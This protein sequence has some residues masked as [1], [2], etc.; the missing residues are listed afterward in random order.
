MTQFLAFSKKELLETW[1]TKKLV[2]LFVIFMIFGLMSPLVAKLTP[3]ILKMSFGEEFPIVAPTSLDSW[4]QYYKNLSQIGIYLFAIVFSGV[5]SQEIQKGTLVHLVTKGLNRSVII[6]SKWFILYL[7]WTLIL[8]LSFVITFGYTYFYF[9]DNASAHPWLA[10]FP[11]LIFGLFFCSL[12]IFTSTV[13][14]SSFEGLL[15]TIFVMILGYIGGVF[16]SLTTWNPVSL[17]G[18]NLVILQGTD[19]LSE[20]LPS[21]LVTLL[22]T[23]VLIVMSINVLKRKKI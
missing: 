18:Q 15:L 10:F 1:R 22:L 3:E 12:I 8:S 14:R 23:I 2:L 13:A 21:I 17:I 11:L 16:E 7:Q 20:Y 4:M 5:I 9:P 6:G 19:R